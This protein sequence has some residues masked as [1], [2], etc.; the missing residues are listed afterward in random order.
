MRPSLSLLSSLFGSRTLSWTQPRAEA[1]TCSGW[2]LPARR[3]GEPGVGGEPRGLHVGALKTVFMLFVSSLFICCLLSC[4]ASVK[5]L[6][7]TPSFPSCAKTNREKAWAPCPSWAAAPG[8]R[9]GG[10]WGPGRVSVGLGLSHR[11]LPALP[12]P[13]MR[14]FKNEISQEAC[15]F[16]PKRV[17]SPFTPPSKPCSSVPS[18]SG[19]PGGLCGPELPSPDSKK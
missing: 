7:K 6:L 16:V 5:F 19:A 18:P 3:T 9:A 2:A 13:T 15:R 14:R 4:G 1:G 8:G 11:E 17:P 10:G 12:P